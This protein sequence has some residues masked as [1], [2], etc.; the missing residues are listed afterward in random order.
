MALDIYRVAAD[1]TEAWADAKEGVGHVGPCSLTTA[2]A[3]ASAGDIVKI[4]AGSY[5]LSDNL[6]ASAT[7]S[8]S[9]PAVFA[10][11]DADWNYID[12]TYTAHGLIDGSSLPVIT[13]GSTSY[14]VRGNNAV[15]RGL[16]VVG[17]RST[18]FLPTATQ[19]WM[20]SII[21][22]VTNNAA[23]GSINGIMYNC[24]CLTTG[25][26]D[27][28]ADIAVNSKLVNCFVRN[29]VK[30]ANS[31]STAVVDSVIVCINEAMYALDL[32]SLHLTYTPTIYKNTLVGGKGFGVSATGA[33]ALLALLNTHIT[34]SSAYAIQTA[35]TGAGSPVLIEHLRHRTTSGAVNWVGDWGGIPRV[36]IDGGSDSADYVDAANNNYRLKSDAP[37]IDAGP[38]EVE[39]AAW[40]GACAAGG[41]QIFL[42]NKR[43]NKQ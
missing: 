42:P 9:Q 23:F 22:N 38:H 21:E 20:H 39:L 41:G 3:N 13:L 14:Y 40:R 11:C 30:I 4:K 35:H 25:Q 43:G 15:W 7:W 12:P 5:S 8:D 33:H 31:L 36:E 10:G 6:E 18:L 24:D 2:L 17:S 1:G 32:S 37:A 28:T 26:S 29:P 19:V 27:F 34:G 16:K